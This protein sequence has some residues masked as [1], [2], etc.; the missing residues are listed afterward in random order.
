M[1]SLTLSHPAQNS[2]LKQ[3]IFVLTVQ[4]IHEYPEVHNT[5]I[6]GSETASNSHFTEPALSDE[7]P[8]ACTAFI[9]QTVTVTSFGLCVT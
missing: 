4:E 8:T 5:F 6:H 9:F 3:K 2:D 7:F 1:L